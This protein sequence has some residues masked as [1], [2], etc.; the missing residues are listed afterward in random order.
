MGDW[1]HTGDATVGVYRA[2][3]WLLRNSNRGGPPDLS[4]TFGVASDTPAVWR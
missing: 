2:G 3:L 1:D 4:L